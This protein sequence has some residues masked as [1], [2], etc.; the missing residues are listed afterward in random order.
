MLQFSH[1][2]GE[3]AR[4][5]M[6]NVCPQVQSR[7]LALKPLAMPLMLCMCDLEEFQDMADMPECSVCEGTDIAIGLTGSKVLVHSSWF[8]FVA[9]DS[10]NDSAFCVP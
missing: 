3:S 6:R 10:D 9:V 8:A 2:S 5:N 1:M 7:L 4:G